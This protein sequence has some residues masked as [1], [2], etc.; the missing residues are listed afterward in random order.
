MKVRRFRAQYSTRMRLTPYGAAGTVTGSCHLV[1]EQGYRL[2]LDCGAYQGSDEEKNGLPFGFDP[3]TVDAV[4]LSHAHI[5]HIGRLPM[6]VRQGYPGKVYAT[7]PTLLFLPVLLQDSLKLMEEE[8]ERLKRKGKEVPPLPWDE[9]DLNELMGRLEAL[10]FHQTRVFGPLSVRLDHAGHL[11]GSGFIR[12][13][14]K[15]RRLVFSGDLGHKH[16]D[17]LPDPEYPPAAQLTLSEGTYGD[18]NHRPFEETLKE[19]A[20]VLKKTFSK[21]G[22]VFIPSF[23]LERTQEILYY[24]R[25]MEEKKA[26]PVV[27]VYVDSPMADRISDIYP[28]V[29]EYFSPEARALYAKGTDPFSTARLDYTKSV[30]ESKALNELDGPLVIIAGSGMISGGRILHHLRHGLPSPNNALVV[31]GYQPRGGIGARLIEGADEIHIMGRAIPVRARTHT[32]GGFSGHAGQDELLDWNKDQ[33]KVAL[34]HGELEKLHALGKL[35][36]ERGKKTW[37]AQWGVPVEV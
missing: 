21:R 7:E 4:V 32:L 13:D 35:L 34:V 29:K 10:P 30:E 2:L 27:P 24:I 37:V 5:D 33:T 36:S 1:E 16:K 20:E 17:V 18:R 31:V 8:R 26:L 28:K 14:S 22:K 23:A 6:L 9:S 12:V 11:P 25:E 19:F 15:D 3:K